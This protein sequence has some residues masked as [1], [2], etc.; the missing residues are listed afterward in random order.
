MTW[1]MFRLTLGSVGWCCIFAN[2]VEFVLLDLKAKVG[3][4]N[5]T[6]RQPIE[7]A[8]ASFEIFVIFVVG[9]R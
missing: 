7:V 3:S 2:C 1:L 4:T 9:L 6:A 5:G 8:V